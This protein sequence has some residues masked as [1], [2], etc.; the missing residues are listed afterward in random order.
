M[1]ERARAL[2]SKIQHS[3]QRWKTVPLCCLFAHLTVAATLASKLYHDTNA[4]SPLVPCA[5]LIKTELCRASVNRPRHKCPDAAHC[6]Q[7]HPMAALFD[8]Q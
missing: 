8:N 3:K 7:F 1:M 2:E 6:Q 5:L 4:H